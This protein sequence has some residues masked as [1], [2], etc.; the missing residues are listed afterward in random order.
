MMLSKQGAE[1]KTKI[2]FEVQ[3]Y[4][5]HIEEPISRKSNHVSPSYVDALDFSYANAADYGITNTIHTT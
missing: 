3:N 2:G 4:T 1:L 5:D